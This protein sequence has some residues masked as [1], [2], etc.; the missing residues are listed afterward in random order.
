M[1]VAIVSPTH[2]AG[3]S[4]FTLL[5]GYTIACTQSDS[6]CLTYT[7]ENHDIK[8]YIG[9]DEE[10]DITRSIEQACELLKADAI[11]ASNIPEFFRRLNKNISLLD[12]ADGTVSLEES[13]QLLAYVM[14]Y[15]EQDVVLCDISTDLTDSATVDIVSTCDVVLIVS[16]P[17]NKW[18]DEVREWKESIPVLQSKP[19]GLI[20]NRYDPQVAPVSILAKRAG[21]TVRNTCKLHY[22]PYIIEGCNKRNLST[23]VPFIVNRDP[24]VVELNMD[25]REVMQFIYSYAGRKIKWDKGNK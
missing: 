2:D 1:K 20:I 12:S 18:L 5:L 25:L 13:T 7:A 22:N 17:S 23:I 21:F 6:V 16:P 8:N 24:R 9:F 14:K 19:C 4:S 11:G 15:I 10:P 3:L